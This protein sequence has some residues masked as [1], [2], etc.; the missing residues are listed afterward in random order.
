MATLQLDICSRTFQVLV[1]GVA[2][3]IPKV[4]KGSYFPAFLEPRRTSETARI[5]YAKVS[6]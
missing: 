1:L 6:F 4:R 2:L 5:S 3:A